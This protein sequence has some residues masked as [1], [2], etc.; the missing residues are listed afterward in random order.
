MKRKRLL[1]FLLSL[2]IW[3]F[4]QSISL[5]DCRQLAHDNYP[6]IRQY[7]MIENMKDYTV[8][9]A[10]KGWLPQI[11]VQVGG[12]AFTDII[13]A[14]EQMSRMGIDMKNY[15]ANGMVSIKQTVYDGGQI[16]IGKKI[17]KAQAE[18]QK[19]Q[20][21]VTMHDINERVEQLFF[22][23]LIID[24]QLNQNDILQKD[25]AVSNQTIKSMIKNG[26]ANQNDLDVISVEQ[27]K[28]E[29][30]ADA[31]SNSRKAYIK[32]L[33]TFIGKPLNENTEV[34]KP[35]MT[36]PMS[37]N[38]RG[39]Q[40]PEMSLFDSQ[41]QL[42]NIQRKQLNSRLRP[43]VGLVGMGILHTKVSDIVHQG[44]LMGGISMSWNIG[45]LYTRKNDIQKIEIQRQ[46]NDNNREIFLFNNR[47]QN[48]ETD[49]NILSLRKQLAKDTQI[50]NLRENIKQTNEKKVKLGTETVN[51]LIRSINAV[52]MAR[53]QQ[54]LHELQLLQAIYHSNTINK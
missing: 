10:A 21:D 7:N 50:V 46:Q 6:A 35:A 5:D 49:G 13:N 12:Y 1:L 3:G 27:M 9:N 51:E 29:Q 38:T 20:L 25:L 18:V 31:L 33:S 36:I 39:L 54:S 15:V 14:N 26:L 11:D 45:A 37:Q 28:A 32:M 17:A 19:R 48:E 42:I 2:P 43:T 52:N 24:E 8:S 44:L 30:Q 47:L 4:A 41:D 23:V 40:R 16:A 34:E 53:Q 22:G